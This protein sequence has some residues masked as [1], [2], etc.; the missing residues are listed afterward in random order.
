M[1]RQDDKCIDRKWIVL[2]SSGDGFAE[3]LDMVHEQGFAPIEEVNCE[4]P[5]SSGDESATVVGHDLSSL[6]ATMAD[7]AFG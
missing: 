7:Y 3:R 5:A 2:A 6:Q 4:E 1:I